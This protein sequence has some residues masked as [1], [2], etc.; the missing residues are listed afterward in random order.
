MPPLADMPATSC[1]C[2]HCMH[3]LVYATKIMLNNEQAMLRKMK[4]RV[5]AAVYG[6]PL[7]YLSL[8]LFSV[9]RLSPL[10]YLLCAAV[11]IYVIATQSWALIEMPL[12]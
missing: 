11:H 5:R 1:T 9:S 2:V 3:H 12:M 6:M 8:A 7:L 10:M 4:D